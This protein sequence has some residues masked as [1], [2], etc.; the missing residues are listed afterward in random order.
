MTASQ[1][2]LIIRYLLIHHTKLLADYTAAKDFECRQDKMRITIEVS[3]P[4][5]A[6]EAKRDIVL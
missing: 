2:I 4:W 1:E 5:A 6:Y 3:Y